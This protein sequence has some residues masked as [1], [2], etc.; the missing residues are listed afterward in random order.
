MTGNEP[1]ADS[2]ATDTVHVVQAFGFLIG[3]SEDEAAGYTVICASENSGTF[4]GHSPTDL[5]AM[6]NFGDV[7]GEGDQ[8]VLTAQIASLREQHTGRHIDRCAVFSLS[9][10]PPHRNEATPFWCSIHTS[11]HG[12]DLVVCEFEPHNDS[13][14]YYARQ[15]SEHWNVPYDLPLNL[16]LEK[17]STSASTSTTKKPKRRRCVG[18]RSQKLSSIQA[19]R[20]MS[21]IQQSLGTASTLENFSN[22]LAK[23]LKDLTGY[24][25]VSVY[26]LTT[27]FDGRVLLPIFETESNRGIHVATL[28]S[29]DKDYRP[30]LLGRM[31]HLYNRDSQPTRILYRDAGSQAVPSIN[32]NRLY[33]N[34]LLPT[35]FKELEDETARSSMALPIKAFEEP[36]GLVVCHSYGQQG[37]RISVPMRRICD[38][39]SSTSSYTIEMLSYASRL[40]DNNP[41]RAGR[42]EGV[43]ATSSASLLHQFDADFALMLTQGEIHTLGEPGEAWQAA[44]IA[45]RSLRSRRTTAVVVSHDVPGDFPAFGSL[46]PSA[47]SGLLSVP[48]TPG[49]RDIVV[50]FRNKHTAGASPWASGESPQELPPGL[51]SQE[52]RERC[53]G[54]SQNRKWSEKQMRLAQSLAA[55][56][57]VWSGAGDGRDGG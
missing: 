24:D 50:F 2:H 21:Q 54:A 16:I 53:A 18:R 43:A 19:I 48:L 31:R 6:E 10:R 28:N 49:G 32:L 55:L 26:R 20:I 36:W 35:F 44:E 8:S 30:N 14:C 57:T 41:V 7:L 27:S 25:R 3:L 29:A 9:I 22:T 4:T 46:S 47:M 12:P 34:A 13:T 17:G 33:L 42:T 56:A 11:L 45:V 52:F 23:T 51:E 5:F 40:P 1:E 38:F 15:I 39:I 37:T